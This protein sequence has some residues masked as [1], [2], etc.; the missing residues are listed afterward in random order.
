MVPR[1]VKP[2]LSQSFFLF[3]PRGV[4]KSTLLRS[5]FPRTQFFWRNLLEP[6]LEARYAASPSALL[7]DWGSASPAQRNNGWI[8]IDEVQKVPKLLDVVHLAIEEHG[9]RFALTGSSARK[10]RHGSSNLLAGRAITHNM[11]AF[12][13]FELGDS[14]DLEDALNFGLLPQA[15]QLRDKYTDRKRFLL[16]YVNTYLRSEI[17]EEQF[18]RKIEPF[19]NFL[20]I[21][22]AASGTTLNISRLGRQVNIENRTVQRYFSLLEDTLIGFYLPAFNRSMRIAQARHP[23]FYFF[24]TGVAR[25]ASLALNT[26]LTASTYEFGR[27]F[28][29]FVV[30]E[31]IKTNDMFEKGYELFYYRTERGDEIDIIACCGNRTLAIEI[32]SAIE[33][34]ISVVRKF[35]RQMH[36]LDGCQPYIFCRT[37]HPSLVEGVRVLPWQQ[38]V[39]ELFSDISTSR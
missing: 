7:Q 36:K 35:A 38:G 3:G 17:R 30:L 9:L 5:L 18:V 12:S 13:A 37:K 28:E 31:I 8:I 25:A 29:H 15:V 6:E 16:S 2:S 39:A 32:K 1:I 11:H 34:D 4:G 14:F 23:K 21:A 24:D 26:R 33:P 22:A 19:R 27:L 20:R 10:L